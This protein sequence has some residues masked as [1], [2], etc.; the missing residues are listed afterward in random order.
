MHK[1]THNLLYAASFPWIER[2]SVLVLWYQESIEEIGNPFIGTAGI[3]NQ[4][5]ARICQTS[6]VFEGDNVFIFRVDI[7]EIIRVKTPFSSP[8]LLPAISFLASPLPSLPAAQLSAINYELLTA[9]NLLF[10]SI[11]LR[12]ELWAF[13][14]ELF[15]DSPLHRF[16]V[17][18]YSF[19]LPHTLS[20]SQSALCHATCA[21]RPL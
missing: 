7:S 16:P 11:F 14:F 20:P 13:S 3:W 4:G 17:S 8:S 18:P 6:K 19:F 9:L 12:F 5:Q 15:I 21:L 1:A 10:L 2:S